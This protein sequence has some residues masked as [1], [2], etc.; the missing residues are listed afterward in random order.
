MIDVTSWIHDKAEVDATVS[1]GRYA[2][3]WQ[4]ASVVR[5][6]VVG[7][8]VSVAS[9][10]IVD[11]ARIGDGTRISHGAFIDPGVV[12]GDN[13]FIGPHVALCNDPWP[14]VDRTGWFD[15]KDL[16][17]G[18]VTVIVVEDGASIGAG[19]VV[20]PGVRIGKR[21]M[22]AA[23]SVVTADVPE[24][25]LWHRNGSVQPID[26]ARIDRRRACST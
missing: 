24:D 15:M 11:G 19:A 18:L 16:A 2:R 14:R 8:D 3:V 7:A 4:F 25:M 10:A 1:I 23:G 20:L 9:C 6:A 12:V 17:G 13:C 26:V 22:V 21:A 5:R